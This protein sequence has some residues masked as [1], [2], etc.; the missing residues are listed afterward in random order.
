MDH[1]HW[2]PRMVGEQNNNTNIIIK[3]LLPAFPLTHN[4][5]NLQLANSQ[6]TKWSVP[7]DLVQEFFQMSV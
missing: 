3:T 7:G 4:T 5:R 1:D 2:S 6:L